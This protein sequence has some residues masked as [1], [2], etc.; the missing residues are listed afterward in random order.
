MVAGQVQW[1]STSARPEK[2]SRREKHRRGWFGLG[3]GPHINKGLQAAWNAHSEATF[4]YEIV[5]EFDEDV[6]PL[7]L[8][9]MFREREKHW[10]K[11]WGASR[12]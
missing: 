6:P 12:L 3:S 5:E 7:L 1:T 4:A 11:E 10:M 8:N 9:D 2:S